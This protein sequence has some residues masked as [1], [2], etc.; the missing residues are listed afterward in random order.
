MDK[1]K[2][3]DTAV[4]TVIDELFEEKKNAVLIEDLVNAVYIKVLSSVFTENKRNDLKGKLKTKIRAI[5]KP[6]GKFVAAG[7]VQSGNLVQK[8]QAAKKILGGKF[9]DL[10]IFKNCIPDHQ[11][12]YYPH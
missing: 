4:D 9:S 3:E 8:V 11:L 12:R 5:S 7:S 2:E 10:W 1:L 6:S